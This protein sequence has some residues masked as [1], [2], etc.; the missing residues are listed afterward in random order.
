M[1]ASNLPLL[2]LLALVFLQTGGL[3]MGIKSLQALRVWQQEIRIQSNPSNTIHFILSRNEFDLYSIDDGKELKING[4]MFDVVSIEIKDDSVLVTA[5]EDYFEARLIAVLIETAHSKAK[6]PS[7]DAFLLA[8]MHLQFLSP[9][10]NE[11]HFNADIPKINSDFRDINKHWNSTW[12]AD[13]EQP[14]ENKRNINLIFS[15]V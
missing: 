4:N 1:R 14:P 11:I 2:G 5:L 10:E 12:H 13:L 15:F 6:N 9:E 7:K 8:L 3:W